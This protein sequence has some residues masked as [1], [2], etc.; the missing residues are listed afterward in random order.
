MQNTKKSVGNTVSSVNFLPV[1]IIEEAMS[2]G[3]RSV[4]K[5]RIISQ[6]Y[7]FGGLSL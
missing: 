2:V 6:R 1:A 3:Y 5:G 7:T 4:S